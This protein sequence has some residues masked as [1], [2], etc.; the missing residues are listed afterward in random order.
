MLF[1]NKNKIPKRNTSIGYFE[2]IQY[3]TPPQYN[4]LFFKYL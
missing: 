4:Y 3:L 1:N 2:N